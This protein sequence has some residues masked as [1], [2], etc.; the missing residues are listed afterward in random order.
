MGMNKS[1]IVRF[2]TGK[3]FYI[4]LAVCLVGAGAT[5][6][7]AVDR[8]ISNLNNQNPDDYVSGVSESSSRPI[9][10][11]VG[12][13]TLDLPRESRPESSVSSESEGS[14]ASSSQPESSVADSNGQH[15]QLNLS[16]VFPLDGDIINPYSSGE[17]VKSL[18]LNDWRTHDGID[19]K[20][21]AAT[22][23]TAPVI[24]PAIISTAI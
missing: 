12:Q 23:V 9:S 3:G 13:N 2:L 4:A 20:A 22:P 10:E 5:A 7:V 18:T 21:K 15:A 17:L 24:R 8:S 19:I 6:W 16:Y 14:Q 11:E 1:K